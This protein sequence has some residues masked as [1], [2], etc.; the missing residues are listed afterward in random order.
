MKDFMEKTSRR[1]G[2]CHE[3]WYIYSVI[4]D[5]VQHWCLDLKWRR[6]KRLMPVIIYCISTSY[7]LDPFIVQETFDEEKRS[8]LQ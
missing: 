8:N 3:S 2:R 1:I 6:G 7:I 5:V 4:L